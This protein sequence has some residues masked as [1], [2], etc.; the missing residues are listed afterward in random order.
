MGDVSFVRAPRVTSYWK[1]HISEDQLQFISFKNRERVILS[2]PNDQAGCLSPKPFPREF[3]SDVRLKSDIH[4]IPSALDKVNRLKEITYRWNQTALDYFTRDVEQMISAGPNAT[5]E[6][7]QK[8]WQAERAR[9]YKELSQTNVGV[10]AQDVEAVL[11]E[12]VTA[13]KAGYKKVAY[14]EPILCLSR[15]SRRKTRSGLRL[16]TAAVLANDNIFEQETFPILKCPSSP[17][18]CPATPQSL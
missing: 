11:P 14:H 18:R 6:A 10:L 3:Q 1:I 9:Q 7:N 5:P 8:M 13:D 16:W 2:I 4:L 12:A 17:K 15:R